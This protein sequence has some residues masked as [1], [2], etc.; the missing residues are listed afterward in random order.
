[1][2]FKN[3]FTL[4]IFSTMMNNILC[5]APADQNPQGPDD[6]PGA[7]PNSARGMKKGKKFAGPP[8]PPQQ[9]EGQMDQP[10]DGNPNDGK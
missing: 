7:S 2:H 4:F 9:D 6:G 1:M 8:P 10:Q 5:G 3:I